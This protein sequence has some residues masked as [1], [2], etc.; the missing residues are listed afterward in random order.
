MI[1]ATNHHNESDSDSV[2]WGIAFESIKTEFDEMGASCEKQHRSPETATDI[3][4]NLVRQ[5]Q[6]NKF[7][8]IYAIVGE[9]LGTGAI[10][11]V[12][13]IRKKESAVGGSSQR[14]FV[15]RKKRRREQKRRYCLKRI[16]DKSNNATAEE[17]P[18][19][20]RSSDTYYALKEINID[21]V[22]SA[23]AMQFMRNEVELLK[24]LDHPSIVRAFETF[25]L[26][27]RLSIV[28][29]LCRGGDLSSRSPY[30]ERQVA[31]IIRQ[32]L[33]A[34]SYMHHQQVLH[35]D[36]KIENILY[37][38]EDP[39]D[40]RVQLI[41]FGLSVKYAQSDRLRDKVGTLYTVA[42]ET[43]QVRPSEKPSSFVLFSVDATK[44]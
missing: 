31:I 37:Q 30:S 42:P 34:V 24:S 4:E 15:K 39:Q 18:N 32:V 25:E 5:Q 12:R 11:T 8:D 27:G 44:V 2:P 16:H 19:T 14:E 17:T 22:Q 6:T 1:R 23:R 3:Q 21:K 7:N 13:K 10:S 9:P 43:L 28:M 35:R 36:L 20:L 40:F 29:E 38:S 26:D 41:D 33:S